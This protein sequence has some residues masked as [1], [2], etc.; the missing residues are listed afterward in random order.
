M[1]GIDMGD[2]FAKVM[3]HAQASGLFENVLGHE[4]TSAPGSGLTCA[5]WVND[6]SPARRRS[7]LAATSVRLEL[8]LRVMTPAD[9]EPQDD[10]DVQMVSATGA[11]MTAYSG[12]FTLDGTVEIDLL[13]AY[14]DPLRAR[15][16]FIGLD[17]TVYRMA[18]IT[19]PLII[20]DAFDQEA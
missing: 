18:A 10:V 8:G 7:G 13:G 20:N 17:S 3:G 4:P 6:L 11:L 1:P 15:F 5:V 2:I 16:G 9:Q 12:D 14:G 19:L